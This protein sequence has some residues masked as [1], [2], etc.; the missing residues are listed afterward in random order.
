MIGN[1][2]QK[3]QYIQLGAVQLLVAALQSSDAAQLVQA[4]AALGSFAA[5][6]QGLQV[7]LQHGGI[8]HLLHVLVGSS[9]DKVVEAAVRALKAVARVRWWTCPAPEHACR[10]LALYCSRRALLRA[11]AVLPG[12]LRLDASLMPPAPTSPPLPA[13]LAG[14]PAVAVGPHTPD[15]RGRGGAAPP[16]LPAWL[17]HQQCGRVSGSGAGL[18]LHR[19]RR[20][21]GGC[22]GGGCSPARRAAVLAAAHQAG[23]GAGGASS[24]QPRQ[25]GD[26][27][28]RVAAPRRGGQPAAGHQAGGHATH[29][30]CGGCLPGQPVPQPAG[31]APGAQPAGVWGAGVLCVG[32]LLCRLATTLR[33]RAPCAEQVC[34]SAAAGSTSLSPSPPPARLQDLQQAVLPVLVRLLGEA[35]VAE[36]VPGALGQLVGD[37]A[38]LQQAA[39]DAD[40]IAK[41]GAILRWAAVAGGSALM[42]CV[43]GDA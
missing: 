10:R 5:S 31:R 9:D 16:S 23:G 35:G 8:P 34:L 38:E 29:P 36:D 4:A 24:T 33:L 2:R 14:P 17:V 7:L 22:C 3:Q 41:L 21:V 19:R 25:R 11:A 30:L 1:R 27:P 32:W 26:I 15:L 6:E 40:A 18:L 39:A 12:M 28:G 42:P 43:L 13:W 20:A 37:N